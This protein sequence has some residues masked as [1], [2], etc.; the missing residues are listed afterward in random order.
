MTYG[1]N[2]PDVEKMIENPDRNIRRN[3]YN[4]AELGATAVFLAFQ[5]SPANEMARVYIGMNV[6]EATHNPLLVGASIGVSKLAIEGVSSLPVARSLN[7]NFETVEKIKSRFKRGSTERNNKATDVALALGVGTAA[8]VIKR[9]I[10]ESDRTLEKDRR[11]IAKTAG[12]IAVFSAGIGALAGGGIEYADKVGLGDASEIAVKVL[13][14]WRTYGVLLAGAIIYNRIR[15]G[16]EKYATRRFLNRG[17]GFG[18]RRV[19]DQ[20]TI[21]EALKLEQKVW[22]EEGFG[23]LN[24]YEK[25]LPQSRIFAAFENKK[26]TGVVRLFSGSPELPPFI[27]EMPFYDEELKKDL[28]ERCQSVEIEEYGTAAVERDN[29]NKKIFLEL[30]RHAY[31]DASERGI[32]KWG[33]IMEPERVRKMNRLLGFTFEQVGPTKIYQGE[34]CAAHIMDFEEV[35]QHMSLTKPELYDWFVNQPLNTSG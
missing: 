12:A 33:I 1:K 8:V 15:R 22:R 7:R 5:Q 20:K 28:S 9:H 4:K 34:E 19:N 18:V 17:S 24:V 21:K 16:I 11:T 27:S 3:L 14:D 26:C 29:R 23:E 31:R 10:Q 35:R 6:L 25:Y 32:E 2:S 30:C 13:S